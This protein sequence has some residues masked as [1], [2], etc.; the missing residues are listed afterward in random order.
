MKQAFILFLFFAG[1][2]VRVSAMDSTKV[3]RMPDYKYYIYAGSFFPVLET[4]LR[5]DGSKAGTYLNLEDDLKLK[6]KGVSFRTEAIMQ[7]SPRSSVSLTY[8]GVFRHG[9]FDLNRDITIDDS[10]IHAGAH[11]NMYFNSRFMGASYRYNIFNSKTWSLGLCTGL[12]V[13]NLDMGITLNRNNGS[14]YS[15]SFSVFIPVA[16]VGIHGSAYITPRFLARYSFEYFGLTIQGVK[17]RVIDNRLTLEYYILKNFSL[18][19]SFTNINYNVTD[20][21][22]SDKFD[23]NVGYSITGFSGYV[24]VRF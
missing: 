23:G 19:C 15:N 6:G 11:G 17:G 24:G 1:I 7:F 5:V 3:A 14:S 9:D 20:F 10:T 16:L 21:P 18:G 2:Q 4:T 22:L 8:F 13:L 12:R